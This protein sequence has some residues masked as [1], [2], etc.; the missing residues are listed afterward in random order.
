MNLQRRSKYMLLKMRRMKDN[1]QKLARGLALGVFLN[2]LP[3]FGTGVFIAILVAR[4]IRANVFLACTAALATKWC[5]PV[6]YTL[7]LKVGQ[8]MLGMPSETL[9]TI[10]VKVSSADWS[11]II[12]LGKPFLVGSVLNSI[13]GSFA[14]YGLFLVLLPMLLKDRRNPVRN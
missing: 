11:G 8:I 5:I 13:V 4:Y 1:P 14:M 12:S 6:L 2:F 7:N 9:R 10:W 3:T